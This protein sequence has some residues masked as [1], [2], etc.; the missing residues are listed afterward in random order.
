MKITKLN[1]RISLFLVLYLNIVYLF[2]HPYAIHPLF[3]RC[4]QINYFSDFLNLHKKKYFLLDGER[5]ITCDNIEINQIVFRSRVSCDHTLPCII[6]ILLGKCTYITRT[7]FPAQNHPVLH[8]YAIKYPTQM[9]MPMRIYIK[10]VY[11]KI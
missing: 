2:M 4:E 6:N 3:C 9:S 8:I 1:T 11:F 10:N 7:D 5:C